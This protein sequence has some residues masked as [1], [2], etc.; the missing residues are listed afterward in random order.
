MLEIVVAIIGAVAGGLCTFVG[1][2]LL[3]SRKIIEYDISSMPLLRFTPGSSH[4][5]NVS[6]DKSVL[7]NNVADKGISMPIE[8]AYGFQIDLYNSGNKEVIEPNIKISLDEKALIVEYESIPISSSL[9][10][11][12]WI[13]DDLN[14]NIVNLVIPYINEHEHFRVRLISTQNV[15][16][17]CDV[18][19]TGVGVKSRQSYRNRPFL[20]FSFCLLLFYSGFFSLFIEILPSINSNMN[21]SINY[22]YTTISSILTIIFGISL[23]MSF[24]YMDSRRK[25]RLSLREDWDMKKHKSRNKSSFFQK[26]LS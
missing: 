15:N 14:H 19:V 25:I 24:K 4:A 20:I 13:K 8:S 3:R 5:L 23:I 11:I 12:K 9:Y 6:V 21:I 22:Y 16:R 26:L 17:E 18:E 7:T 2:L 1:S 10:N